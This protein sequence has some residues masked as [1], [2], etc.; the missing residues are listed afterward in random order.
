MRV[1]YL[2]L[3]DIKWRDSLSWCFAVQS[4]QEK[5]APW[6]SN[7]KPAF[8]CTEHAFPSLVWK[9]R[10]SSVICPACCLQWFVWGFTPKCSG[11]VF[12]ICTSLWVCVHKY[13]YKYTCMCLYTLINNG[14]T[15]HW[16]EFV[17]LLEQLMKWDP[18][19]KSLSWETSLSKK[20]KDLLSTSRNIKSNTYL[21]E[22]LYMLN[23]KKPPFSSV[24]NL[25]LKGKYTVLLSQVHWLYRQK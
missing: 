2:C 9:F 21:L 15:K 4:F 11:T 19:E 18:F 1:S 20:V 23:T 12:H 14:W 16:L 24:W 3:P 25:H 8:H 7:S 17:P 6:T 5:K 10:V 22:H 13:L